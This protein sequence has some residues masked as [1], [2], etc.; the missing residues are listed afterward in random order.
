MNIGWLSASPIATTGYGGQTKEVCTRLSEKHNV[1]CIAQVGDVIVWGGRQKVPGTDLEVLA[2]SDFKSA[3][4]LLNNDYIPEYELDIIIGFM[5]AFGIEFLN[6]INIPVIGWI[7][8]DGPF[9]DA[10]KH[11][12]RHYYKVTTYSKFGYEE[13]LKFFPPSK[14]DY[15]P[16]G[17]STDLF[18]PC[19]DKERDKIRNEFEEKYGIPKDATLYLNVGVN[20]GPRKELPLMMDTF[21][22]FVDD[23]YDDAYLFMHT[24]AYMPVRGYDLIQWRGMMKMGENIHFPT[25]NP[26][27]NPISNEDLA[28]IYNASDVYVQNSVAEGFGLPIVEALSCSKP[29]ITAWNSAQKEL[30]KGHGWITENVPEDMYKQI[31]VYVPQLTEY[32]VPNQNSL[33]KNLEASYTSPAL[34]EYYGNKGRDFVLQNHSWDTVMSQWFAFLENLEKELQLFKDMKKAFQVTP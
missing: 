3:P 17:I 31:P 15:I 26:I 25:Y 6:A 32:P 16:H 10:W 19:S 29:V 14:L 1:V 18:K 13:L 5:D 34:R 20:M 24:N 30:V 12:L 9:T 22:R 21:K 4:D 11:Y 2:L 23:G 28:K 7:P 27:V 8:I 33:L